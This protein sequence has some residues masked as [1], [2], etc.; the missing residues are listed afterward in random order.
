MYW[1]NVEITYCLWQV[2]FYKSIFGK[3]FLNS[4]ITEEE[5]EQ[6]FNNLLRG[7]EVLQE[8]NRGTLSLVLRILCR[9]VSL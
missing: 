6:K 4:L 9:Y 8:H 2:F 7:I 5:F 3:R 1:D